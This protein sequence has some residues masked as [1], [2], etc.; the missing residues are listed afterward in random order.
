MIKRML[1][2]ITGFIPLIVGAQVTISV[3]LPP[4]GLIQKDQLWNLVLVNNNNATIE[5]TVTLSLQEALTGQ[6]VLSAGTRSFML[7][8]G[9]KMIN[10][11]DIQPVQYN[12]VSAELTGN[13]IPLGSYI[14][15]YRV[16]K[17]S[18]EVIEPIADECVRLDINPLSPPLLNT[19]ADKSV[20]Q[21]PYPQFSW[22]GPTPSEMFSQL[23]YDIAVAEVLQ[24]Q[25]PAEAI[26]NN[27][28]VYINGN[29]RNPFE[30][31]PSSYSSLQPGK[32]YAWQV[33]ARN[34]LNYSARTEVWTF[35]LPPSDSSKTIA[36]NPAYIL[37]GENG[38][39]GVNIITDKD[40]LVKYYSFYD[41]PEAFV[42]ILSPDGK[43]MQEV[44]QRIIYGDNFLLFKLNRFFKKD[45]VYTLEIIDQQQKK[46]SIQFSIKQSNQSN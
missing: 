30:S 22:I 21:T 29:I 2:L 27:V 18:I 16:S 34:G 40:L 41:Q 42:R 1:I 20:I 38:N 13:F 26:L 35:N 39:A 19:P 25:S 36:T 33:T 46:H 5:A 15:C 44:K 9:V 24:G 8:K 14:A 45:Q 4:A 43:V 31:Y 28:P 17:K 6:T 12:Y 11:R 3:Q 37:L 23:N 10:Y 7:G 32:Q